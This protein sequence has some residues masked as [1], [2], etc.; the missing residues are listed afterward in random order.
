L[1]WGQPLDDP[2]D[3][4][5]ERS[6]VAGIGAFRW[7]AWAWLAI[8]LVVT[9]DDLDMPELAA[10]LAAAAL[11]LTAAL[12]ILARRRSPWV[13]RAPTA[14]AEL[15][16]GYALLAADGGVYEA[17]HPLSLGSAWPL[18]GAITLGVVVGPWGG[19]VAGV[20]LGMGRLTG[21]LL[22]DIAQPS[23]LSLLST[24]VLYGM[25]GAVA[26]F[27]MERL[28][29]AE[30]EISAARAREEIA[31]QLHDG[32]LQTLAV[33]QRRSTDADLA[34]L[35][36]DQER[37]LRDFLFGADAAGDQLGPSLR[38]AA[39]RFERVHGRRA[40]VVLVGRLPRLP[41][42]TR[43]AII[44]AVAEALNNAAKHSRAERATVYVEALDHELFCSVKDN[45]EGFRSDDTSEGVGISRSIR[46]RIDEVGG[47]A[48]IDGNPGRG[49]EVRLW[50][51]T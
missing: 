39:A 4:R 27:G 16:A 32:V 12:T 7:A 11:A 21:T 6:V 47:R 30:R 28:R 29:R 31:R 5:L 8:T 44:G 9:R 37:E 19:L 3:A 45:G 26:G 42:A 25:A 22:D 49:T 40:E 33:V 24:A 10:A 20:V 2:A 35:A 38:Q 36:R 34:A 46:A 41:E 13:L 23:S 51:P 1:A 50:V 18:A 48:E 15:A 43:E 17:D 14:L